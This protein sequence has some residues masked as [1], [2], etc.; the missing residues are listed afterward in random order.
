[1]LLCNL[2]PTQYHSVGYCSRRLIALIE[3]SV[4]AKQSGI[5]WHRYANTAP[6]KLGLN[7]CFLTMLLRF[8]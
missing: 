3:F 7:T 4:D 5:P 1:M 6:P 8:E 2:D